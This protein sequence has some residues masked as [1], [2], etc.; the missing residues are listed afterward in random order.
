MPLNLSV[1]FGNPNFDA[2]ILNMSNLTDWS[3]AAA[4]TDFYVN[5][6]SG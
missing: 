4:D 2:R 6:I 3:N 1:A 5:P